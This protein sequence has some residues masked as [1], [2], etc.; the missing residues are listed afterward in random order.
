MTNEPIPIPVAD[1]AGEL[2]DFDITIAG[3]PA[4]AWYAYL[5]GLDLG[6][7]KDDETGEVVPRY[8]W[9]WMADVEGRQLAIQQR[10]SRSTG[11]RSMPYQILVALVGSAAVKPSAVFRASELIGREAILTVEIAEGRSRV[12]AVTAVPKGRKSP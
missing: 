6:E 12:V 2:A 3:A 9:N 8:V 10:T 5:A 1:E 11:P 7:W 4:G